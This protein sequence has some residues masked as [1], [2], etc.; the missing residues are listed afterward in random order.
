MLKKLLLFVFGILL[1]ETTL[2]ALSDEEVKKSMMTRQETRYKGLLGEQSLLSNSSSI[3]VSGIIVD[4]SGNPLNDV[5]LELNFSRP[6]GWESE[7]L[8]RKFIS[9]SKFFITQAKYT[10][11]TV[12]FRKK[13]YFEERMFYSTRISSKYLKNGIFSKTDEKIILREIGKLAKLKKVEKLLEYDW[14]N[15][16]KTFFNMSTM[17][18]ETLPVDDVIKAKKYIYLDFERDKDG[19]VLTTKNYNNEPIPKAFIIR[20]VSDDKKDGFIVERDKKDFSYLPEAPAVDYNQ[21]EII[22]P[23]KSQDIYFYYRNGDKYGKGALLSPYTSYGKSRIWLHLFQ[24][25]ETA[26]KEKRNLRSTAY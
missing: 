3:Y 13:G 16:R 8:T 11:L 2:F 20:Y 19:N 15:K 22:V 26:P 1:L 24:N 23:L 17:T 10:G 18:L 5:E 7:D 9:N 4:D 14:K 21:K 12:Y 6:K 25:N